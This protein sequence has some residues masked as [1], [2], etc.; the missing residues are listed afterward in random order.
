MT[1]D[2][3]LAAIDEE[4]RKLQQ[5]RAML[6]SSPSSPAKK[7]IGRPRGAKTQKAPVAVQSKKRV[8]SEEARA[9]IA[10]AQTKRWAAARKAAK[11]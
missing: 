10:A 9:R 4:I 8:L 3:I 5:A 11:Q 6:S 1:T 2:A 7:S